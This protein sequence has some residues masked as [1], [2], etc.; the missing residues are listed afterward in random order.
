MVEDEEEK[1]DVKAK[2]KDGTQIR[3]YINSITIK[4]YEYEIFR[5]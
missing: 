2:Q 4:C 3:S 1:T 5:G